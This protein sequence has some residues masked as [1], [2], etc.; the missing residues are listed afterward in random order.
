MEPTTKQEM[1]EKGPWSLPWKEAA[2]AAG[3]YQSTQGKEE[4]APSSPKKMPWEYS[5]T[6][7]VEAAKRFIGTQPPP[8]P[9]TP[10]VAPPSGL[11]KAPA[12]DFSLEKNL[13]SLATLSPAEQARSMRFEKS[14]ANLAML[15]EEL[16]RPGLSPEAKKALTEER[17]RLIKIRGETTTKKEIGA[18]TDAGD[19]KLKTLLDNASDNS[20]FKTLYSFLKDKDS[21]PNM[22]VDSSLDSR[23]Q[24]TYGE[25]EPAEGSITVWGSSKG[26]VSTLI[27]EM[28][29]AA[30][31]QMIKL[32][33]DI[34]E[35]IRKG[36]KVSKEEKQFLSNWKKSFGVRSIGEGGGE[37]V[38]LKSLMKSIADPKWLSE[39]QDYRTTRA[40]AI[41]HGVGN[42]NKKSSEIYNLQSHM[43]PSIAT[44]FMILLN[45]AKGIKRKQ[46]E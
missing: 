18:S 40:E 13:K 33:S 24:F 4:A 23:G 32:S 35:S 20:D 11:G 38:G 1:P 10:V 36:E 5:I 16:A 9:Q 30:D 17:A 45:Q 43:D 25:G 29:H 7:A 26:F 12:G 21:L 44:E 19:A 15:D 14:D 2:K 3:T 28:T 8:K 41:A 22:K 46:K 27:H 42:V 6:E 31:R 39:N 37:A 34:E